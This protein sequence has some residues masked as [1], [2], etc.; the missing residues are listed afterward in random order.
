MR[1]GGRS[2]NIQRE[3]IISKHLYYGLEINLSKFFTFSD[4]AMTFWNFLLLLEFI[5]CLGFKNKLKY[6]FLKEFFARWFL[7]ELQATRGGLKNCWLKPGLPVWHFLNSGIANSYWKCREKNLCNHKR[8]SWHE[9]GISKFK[10]RP[11]WQAWLK[12]ILVPFAP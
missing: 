7:L 5:T 1:Q 4:E 6:D 10:E 2:Y 12:N 11:I 9:F 8:T 3:Q